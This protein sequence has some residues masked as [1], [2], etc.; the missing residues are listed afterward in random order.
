MIK[1]FDDYYYRLGRKQALVES[2]EGISKTLPTGIPSHQYVSWQQGY[3]DMEESLTW[4]RG[5]AKLEL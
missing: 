5:H 2:N 3:S 1:K 4:K